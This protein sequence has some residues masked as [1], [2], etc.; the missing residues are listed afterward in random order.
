MPKIH[1]W[2]KSLRLGVSLWEVS[3]W[4]AHH[5]TCRSQMYP[6][7]DVSLEFPKIKNFGVIV[8]MEVHFAKLMKDEGRR[9]SLFLLCD[10][11]RM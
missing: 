9:D 1:I 6:G 7:F 11:E 4:Q 5:M 10:W 3:G 2:S 8:A